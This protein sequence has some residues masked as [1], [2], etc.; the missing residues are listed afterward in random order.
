MVLLISHTHCKLL[1][2]FILFLAVSYDSQKLQLNHTWNIASPQNRNF[3]VKIYRSAR[4][5]GLDFSIGII[6]ATLFIC[7]LADIPNELTLR[8]MK[9]MLYSHFILLH[10]SIYFFFY[11]L[12]SAKTCMLS[13]NLPCAELKKKKG[14]TTHK[15]I[16]AHI[17]HTTNLTELLYV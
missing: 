3:Q 12:T 13:R 5:R 1:L 8:K 4:K 11:I 17:T 9:I 2:L 10:F 16:Q 15:F 7:Y 14:N 6:A